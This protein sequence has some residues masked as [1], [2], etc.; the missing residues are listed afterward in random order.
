[1]PSTVHRWF[2]PGEEGPTAGPLSYQASHCTLSRQSAKTCN[3]CTGNS[4]SPIRIL[5]PFLLRDSPVPYFGN[6]PDSI[7]VSVPVSSARDDWHPPPSLRSS[8]RRSSTLETSL[9][10]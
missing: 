1:M 9:D 3:R 5:P 6:S 10:R 4:L 8:A 7:P 2:P